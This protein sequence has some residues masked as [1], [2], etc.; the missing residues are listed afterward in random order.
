MT[1]K[2]IYSAP[3]LAGGTKI[4]D[5]AW[6]NIPA[7]KVDNWLWRQDYTPATE[8]KLAMIDGEGL[9]VRMVCRESDPVARHTEYGDEVWVD[10]AMEFFFAVREGG[11]YI[12]LEMNSVGNKLVGVGSG[13]DV[14]GSIDDYFPCPEVR[15]RVLPGEWSAEC[16]FK[17]SDL[18]RVFGDFPCG[19]GA[20][21]YGN[22]FK[23]GEE[24]GRPHY[25]VWSPI[26]WPKPDFHRP[27]F[28]GKI[29]FE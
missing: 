18:D 15:A 9:A 16:F 1:A 11:V 19:K 25:G 20:V 7:A 22:F 2:P 23:V 5:I 3:V 8:A 24:T 21:L 26:D 27:E 13:R 17:K 6:D 14:R 10:S 28:F 4:T 29:V 12:N